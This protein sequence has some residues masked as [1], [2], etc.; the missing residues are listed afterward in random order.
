MFRLGTT[1]SQRKAASLRRPRCRHSPL[2]TGSVR[3]S[4]TTKDTRGNDDVS[5]PISMNG[6]AHRLARVYSIPSRVNRPHRLR[7]TFSIIHTWNNHLRR[8]LIPNVTDR[9]IPRHNRLVLY[10]TISKLLAV[11]NALNVQT[12][13]RLFLLNHREG[14]CHFRNVRQK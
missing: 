1:S 12:C 9:Q 13:S 11:V 10:M 2:S 7:M 8:D 3:R 4:T 6:D 14:R 5:S